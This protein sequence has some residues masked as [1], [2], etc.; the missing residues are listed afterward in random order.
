LKRRKLLLAPTRAQQAGAQR[1]LEVAVVVEPRQPV[2]ERQALAL[3]DE[4]LGG[5]AL[6]LGRARLGRLGTA[7]C[8]RRLARRQLAA[9]TQDLLLELLHHLVLD[10]QE[11]GVVHRL[12]HRVLQLLLGEGLGEEVVHPRLVDGLLGVLQLRGGRHEDTGG[13]GLELGHPLEQVDS[14]Q[15]IPEVLVRDDR[16]Q[17]LPLEEFERFFSGPGKKDREVLAQVVLHQGQHRPIVL[18]YE[19]LRSNRLSHQG[20][21]MQRG[22]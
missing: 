9:W 2:A 6:G 15:P 5:D 10:G 14:H 18:D 8:R 16:V 21:P 3:G 17:L 1:L 7:R 20:R 12:P 13:M 19:D 22:A 4:R 11:R